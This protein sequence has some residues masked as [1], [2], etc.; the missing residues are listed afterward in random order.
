LAGFPNTNF[1]SSKKTRKLIDNNT[2]KDVGQNE[3]LN[4]EMLI[5]MSPE[6]IVTFGIDN[7]NP[8]DNLTKSGL[9]VLFIQAD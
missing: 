8:I 7:N 9:K 1:I 3:K 5:E 4:I 2:V 6:L